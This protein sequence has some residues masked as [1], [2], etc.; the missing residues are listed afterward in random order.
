MVVI[1]VLD[2]EG[3]VLVLGE[4]DVCLRRTSV[5]AKAAL[6]ASMGGMMGLVDVAVTKGVVAVRAAVSIASNSVVLR[7]SSSSAS[8][9]SNA[10]CSMRSSSLVYSSPELALEPFIA[11][12]TW[13]VGATTAVGR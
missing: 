4:E 1:G 8:S 3:V 7:S 6:L 9:C 13:G 12:S 2:K 10:S 11:S 5:T